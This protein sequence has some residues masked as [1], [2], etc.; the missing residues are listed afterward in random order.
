MSSNAPTV[1][2]R[3]LRFGA[4]LTALVLAVALGTAELVP[5]L[6]TTLVVLQALAF[7][8]GAGL[9]PGRS[10]YGVLFKR[11]VR[12]RLGPP[13]ETED[14]RPPRF[15]QAVGLFFTL[16]ALVGVVTGVAALTLTAL[17]LALVAAVLNA[18][19][20]L[21]LGCETYLLYRRLASREAAQA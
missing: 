19:V 11:A 13:S 21:C 5:A 2:P 4:A 6:S 1:D 8:A 7:A 12:P 14:A 17:A 9:G 18:S 3:G 16:L 15:A 20:G 10:P